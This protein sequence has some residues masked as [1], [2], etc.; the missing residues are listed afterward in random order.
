MTL[1]R[2]VHE[3]YEEEQTMEILNGSKTENNLKIIK[4]LTNRCKFNIRINVH[5]YILSQSLLIIFLA[6][7]VVIEGGFTLSLKVMPKCLQY[8]RMQR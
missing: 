1:E 8:I 4:Y 2:H 5:S 3:P 7:S 6:K